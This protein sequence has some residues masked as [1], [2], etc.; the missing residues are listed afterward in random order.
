MRPIVDG[1]Y[2]WSETKNAA[3]VVRGPMGVP[4]ARTSFTLVVVSLDDSTVIPDVRET[5]DGKEV[6]DHTTA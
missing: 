5:C 6:W 3:D 1:R 4:H 2:A